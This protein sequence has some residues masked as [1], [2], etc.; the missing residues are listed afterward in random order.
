MEKHIG[1]PFIKELLGLQCV[2]EFGTFFLYYWQLYNAVS[3]HSHFE[4]IFNAIRWKS[5]FKICEWCENRRC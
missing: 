2:G 3:Q 1:S 5:R 4:S